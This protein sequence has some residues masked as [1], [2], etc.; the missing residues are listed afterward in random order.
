MSVCPVCGY[1]NTAGALICAECY[2]SL[3][4]PVTGE[5]D[6]TQEKDAQLLEKQN[7]ATTRHP[8][9]HVDL[10]GPDS[11]ALYIGGVE[12]PL[13]IQLTY[14]AI[15]GRYTPSSIAQ[16]RVDL[17]PYGAYSKGVSRLHAAIRRTQDNLLVVIDLDSTNG[18]WLN[19]M[20]LEPRRLYALRSGDRL[21]LGQIEIEIH[22]NG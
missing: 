17:A 13:I 15:L 5:P 19:G 1:N 22:F 14:E 2:A 6:P 10:L 11:V 9:R 21:I 4:G 16:P 3:S 18:S 8:T 20:R 12:E 7:G